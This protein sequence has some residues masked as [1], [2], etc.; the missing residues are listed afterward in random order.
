MMAQS[1]LKAIRVRVQVFEVLFPIILST[2][3][4]GRIDEIK[5]K[6]LGVRDFMMKPVMMNQLKKVISEIL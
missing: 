2:G 6:E 5:A 3:Y 4:S 1:K